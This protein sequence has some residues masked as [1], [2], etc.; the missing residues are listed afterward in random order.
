MT[1]FSMP[2][3]VSP[4]HQMHQRPTHRAHFHQSQPP[5]RSTPRVQQDRPPLSENQSVP[6]CE[7]RPDDVTVPQ[8]QILK[9]PAKEVQ[10]GGEAVPVVQDAVKTS[11]QGDS[12]DASC[13][14]G[15]SLFVSKGKT[16]MCV[17][18]EMAR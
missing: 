13:E 7:R 1:P 14:S 18:N 10:D 11:E 15:T 5:H 12:G 4:N 8:I 17:V 16:P 9:N 2:F 6:T 3:S